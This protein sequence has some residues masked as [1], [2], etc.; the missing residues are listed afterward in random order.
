MYYIVICVF[1]IF[2]LLIKGRNK[3]Y[4]LLVVL[5]IISF[6]AGVFVDNKTTVDSFTT[7][8]NIIY[9]VFTLSLIIVPWNNFSIRK[10]CITNMGFF[11]FFKKCL[12]FVLK[13]TIL[14]NILVLIL[15]LIFIPDIASFKNSRVF[16]DVYER[17]PY[18]SFLFRYCSISKFL[19]LMA[20]PISAYFFSV[21]NKKEATKAL[22]LSTS[23]LIGAIAF[24]SRAQILTY[25][26]LLVCFFFL[27]SNTFRPDIKRKLI[28]NVKYATIVIT[29]IFLAISISRFGSMS[30][31]GD[32]IPQTSLIKE[33]ISYS[34]FDYTSKGFPNGVDQLEYH[35]SEDVLYGKQCTYSLC[36][37]LSFIHLIDWKSEEALASFDRSY[38]KQNLDD[39]D[40]GSFHGY[41]CRMVKNFG[42]IISLLINIAFY[43]YVKRSSYSSVVSIQKLMI[44]TFLLVQPVVAIFYMDYDLYSFPLLFF[45]FVNFFYR[46]V[47]R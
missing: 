8:L 36:L 15:I 2:L 40:S 34:I 42:Y 18:F 10:I 44:L 31:Y 23:T 32:R 43:L 16:I 19:G 37:A 35:Q 7:L 46:L 4:K 47:L 39:N 38:S 20:F 26:L 3:C 1:I 24:Y 13:Y 28:K 5:Q 22:L 33:P 27:I 14:N 21:N 9:C 6:V 29:L 25:F 41:T 17:I 45:L 30:Y 11:L 12:Y